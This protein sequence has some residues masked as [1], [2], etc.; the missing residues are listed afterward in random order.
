LLGKMIR[1]RHRANPLLDGSLGHAYDENIMAPVAE[2]TTADQLFQEPGLGR[3]ELLQGEVVLMSPSGS[4][5]AVVAAT[6][7][8]ILY[9]FV[10]QRKLGWV[11][12]AEG[13]FL[14][15]RDPD[16]VRAPDAAFVSAERMPPS[17]PA[18]FFP[19]PP[20]L[21]VEVLS[22]ND[23]ASDV[24]ARVSD[25]LETGCRKVWVIDPKTQSVT[26]YSPEAQMRMLHVADTLTDDAVLPGFRIEVR[27]IFPA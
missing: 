2:I 8:G 10:Q 13:G 18:G 26:V 12:G 23:R 27:R 21:A 24:F 17:V 15:R 14:I 19:G 6:L 5:H 9:D 22:P 11:F 3:C 1:R 16:T 7:G 4:L 25:W 20:D